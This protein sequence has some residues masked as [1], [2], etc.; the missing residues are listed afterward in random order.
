MIIYY[1]F[2]KPE[3]ENIKI[4]TSCI[5]IPKNIS[6]MFQ[7]V[8]P[9]KMQIK[10]DKDMNFDLE[11]YTHAETKLQKS[12]EGGYTTDLH[13]PYEKEKNTCNY[14]CDLFSKRELSI[15]PLFPIP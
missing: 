9:D 8:I 5:H 4:Q 14:L 13:I 1:L 15:I 2:M 12:L 10:K 7:E 3:K 6:K 11:T